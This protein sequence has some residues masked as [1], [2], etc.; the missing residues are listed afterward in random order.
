[1]SQDLMDTLAHLR[2]ESSQEMD[3]ALIRVG[4]ATVEMKTDSLLPLISVYCEQK[5]R[6]SALDDA[7]RITQSYYGI[8]VER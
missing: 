7:L 1:M 3:K 4:K 8:P 2:E 5:G 6:V